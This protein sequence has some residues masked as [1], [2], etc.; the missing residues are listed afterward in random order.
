MEDIRDNDCLTDE[1]FQDVQKSQEVILDQ[2]YDVVRNSDQAK[3]WL[4]TPL[5]KSFRMYLSSDKMRQMK[6]SATE[7]DP[8]T[9]E[10]ARFN[11]AVV[12]KVE[13]LFGSI[14]VGGQEALQQLNQMN[15]GDTN[16]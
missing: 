1:E 14:L 2:L 9:R 12:C 8:E 5:G 10:K 13:E 3:E 7:R 15:E 4:N 11:F 6:L 16:G